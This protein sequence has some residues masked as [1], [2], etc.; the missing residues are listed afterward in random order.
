ME[1]AIEQLARQF[2]NEGE[3]G[4]ALEGR[5]KDHRD[6]QGLY[7]WISSQDPKPFRELLVRMYDEEIRLRQEIWQGRHRDDLDLGDGIYDCA[8]L[9]HCCGNPADSLVIWKANRLNQDIGELDARFLVG[10]GIDE[11]LAYLRK[12]GGA[13]ARQITDHIN[14]WIGWGNAASDLREWRADYQAHLTKS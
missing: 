13:A 9:L 6:R 3:I 11:T 8:F 5:L 2:L 12:S 14:E 7:P 1:V 4:A 10:A